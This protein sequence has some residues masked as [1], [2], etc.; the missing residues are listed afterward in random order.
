[1]PLTLLKP[2]PNV[3]WTRELRGVLTDP[4][5]FPVATTVWIEDPDH[6]TWPS[7]YVPPEVAVVIGV[8]HV[9]GFVTMT[10]AIAWARTAHVARF[11]FTVLYGRS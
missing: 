5:D 10:D 9:M 2:D 3:P 4:R 7:F 1:M 8:A 6:T 11:A